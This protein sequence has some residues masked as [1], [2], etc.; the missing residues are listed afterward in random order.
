MMINLSENLCVHSVGHMSLQKK[1][2]GGFEKVRGISPTLPPPCPLGKYAY[3]HILL[4][5][6]WRVVREVFGIYLYRMIGLI[7]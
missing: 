7:L 3:G 2:Q 4:F 1:S 6:G 5:L